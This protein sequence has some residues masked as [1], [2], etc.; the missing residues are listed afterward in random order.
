MEKGCDE[1]NEK[2][3]MNNKIHMS[4]IYVFLCPS[5]ACEWEESV[6]AHLLC[7]K[8]DAEPK[9]GEGC[10]YLERKEPHRGFPG[11]VAET[12]I[13]AGESYGTAITQ[14]TMDPSLTFRHN[15]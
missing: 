7:A 4:I 5:H 13:D 1:G 14:G 2:E 12:Q 3:G 9:E 11:S 8:R 6:R 10:D 15:K